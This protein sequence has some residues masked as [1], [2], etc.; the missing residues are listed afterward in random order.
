MTPES[1]FGYRRLVDL[2]D[3]MR[4]ILAKPEPLDKGVAALMQEFIHIVD[5]LA[6]ITSRN[7]TIHL[8][9]RCGQI[10]AELHWRYGVDP[11][12]DWRREKVLEHGRK[13]L[14][15]NRGQQGKTDARLAFVRGVAAWFGASPYAALANQAS[16]APEAGQYWSGPDIEAQ[17]ERFLK[18]HGRKL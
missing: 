8:A 14:G 7:V 9:G 5:N 3:R 6:T 2:A 17:I 10:R 16:R 1:Y 12:T 18:V 4:A 15:R 11:E 13:L